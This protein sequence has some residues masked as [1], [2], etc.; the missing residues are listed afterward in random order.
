MQSFAANITAGWEAVLDSA[1]TTVEKLDALM[2]VDINVLDRFRE[3]FTIQLGWLLDSQPATADLA[4]SFTHPPARGEG[5]VAR[6]V[7]GRERSSCRVD[8]ATAG[9]SA[10]SSSSGCP[11]RSSARGTRPALAFG[12]ETLLRGAATRS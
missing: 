4:W 2:W 7:R 9:R 1:S 3:E 8:Q 12:R 6:A 5:V 11:R 10:C